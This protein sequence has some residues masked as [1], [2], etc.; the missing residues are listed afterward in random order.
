MKKTEIII[1]SILFLSMQLNRKEK[2]DLLDA[3]AKSAKLTKAEIGKLLS[4]ISIAELT[5]LGLIS[6]MNKKELIDAIASGSKL[7]KADAGRNLD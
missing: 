2:S 6:G 7:T 5:G 4:S 1:R 3:I